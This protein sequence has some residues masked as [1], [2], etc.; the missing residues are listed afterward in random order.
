MSA[1]LKLMLTESLTRMQ[2][3]PLDLC[4]LFD[5]DQLLR[6]SLISYNLCMY[7]TISTALWAS[8]N[9]TRVQF[10]HRF[11]LKICT[12]L[13]AI[14]SQRSSADLW[15]FALRIPCLLNKNKTLCK[16]VTE[17]VFTLNWKQIKRKLRSFCFIFHFFFQVQPA[18]FGGNANNIYENLPKKKE[19]K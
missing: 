9:L 6:W 19:I 8:M 2:P 17:I 7:G 10:P 13:F 15:L 11:R 5:Q 4:I 3:K 16:N 18:S 1:F 12:D 14:N